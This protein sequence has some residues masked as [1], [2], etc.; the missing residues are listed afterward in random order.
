MAGELRERMTRPC[1][2][3]RSLRSPDSLSASLNWSPACSGLHSVS[4]RPCIA[5]DAWPG[6]SAAL[7]RCLPYAGSVLYAAAGCRAMQLHAL[8]CKGHV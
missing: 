5:A 1:S 2:L 6:L 3:C 7:L 8:Y 4:I